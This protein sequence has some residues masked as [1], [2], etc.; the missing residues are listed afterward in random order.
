MVDGDTIVVRLFNETDGKVRYIGIDT[1]ETK[2]PDKGVEYY[3]QEATEANK[4]QVDG[5]DV[6]LEPD[7]QRWDWYQRLLAYA[8]FED[9]Y[10]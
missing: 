10:S 6:E 3:G 4:R 9:V 8:Y 5:K 7:V 2:H 1:P